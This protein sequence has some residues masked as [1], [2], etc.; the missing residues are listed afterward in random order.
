M[1][2]STNVN[3]D[4]HLSS[5]L[6]FLRVFFVLC[7][8]DS[9]NL[10]LF[11][12]LGISI[13][14]YFKAT[15][16]CY[17]YFLSMVDWRN[18]VTFYFDFTKGCTST[19][20]PPPHCPPPQHLL[21]LTVF[22]ARSRRARI[23]SLRREMLDLPVLVASPQLPLTQSSKNVQACPAALRLNLEQTLRSEE[24]P[25]TPRVLLIVKQSDKDQ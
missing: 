24:R 20:P 2:K 7:V 10:R 21:K 23:T 9:S 3:L 25:S 11:Q 19:P 12:L 18:G 6:C 14:W 8:T 16:W 1:V 22:V 15:V 4:V 17:F 13:W 5:Y